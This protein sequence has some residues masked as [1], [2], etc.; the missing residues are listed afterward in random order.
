[1][2]NNWCLSATI[3]KFGVGDVRLSK[4]MS[5]RS[6]FVCPLER[7]KYSVGVCLSSRKKIQQKCGG[8][9]SFA[10]LFGLKPPKNKAELAAVPHFC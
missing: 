9:A 7:N 1:M 3:D 6:V 10:A 5:S 2:K 4:E 8:T